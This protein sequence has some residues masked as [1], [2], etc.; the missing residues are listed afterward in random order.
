MT[1]RPAKVQDLPAI[2]KLVKSYPKQ[3]MQYPLPKTADFFVAIENGK[4]VGCCALEIYSKRIAEVR[5]L[6]VQKE[7]Q[8]NGIAS[9]LIAKCISKAKKHKIYE[10]LSITAALKLFRKQGFQTFKQ[11]KY[12]LL[13]V[14]G[15]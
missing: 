5:S 2:R 7:F 11:E 13:K 8:R 12:A 15:K 14:L 4:V 3:L 6:A 1:I 10:L 9:Q